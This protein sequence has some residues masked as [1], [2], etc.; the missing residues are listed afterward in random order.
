MVP[1]YITSALP[2]CIISLLLT[3]S[4]GYETIPDTTVTAC[5]KPQTAKKLA[6]L[7]FP[8]KMNYLPVSKIPKYE[9]LYAI[10][11]MTEIVNPL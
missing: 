1:V 4:K 2:D 6:F 7:V 10:I 5:A 11:P 8:P 9:A 3:V